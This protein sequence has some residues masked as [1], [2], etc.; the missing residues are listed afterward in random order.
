MATSIRP[1]ILIFASIST[2]ARAGEPLDY[3]HDVA[4]VMSRFG[5]NASSCHGKAEG[6]NGFKLS[7]FGNDPQ[8]DY[9][10]LVHQ[11]RGRRVFTAAPEQSLLLLKSSGEMPHEGGVQLEIG[12][13]E[14][15]QLLRWIEAGAP[16]SA[17][18]ERDIV[19]L[20]LEPARRVMKFGE[21][22]ELRAIA[23]FAGGREEDVS[24]LAEF[25]S[26]DVSMAEVDER[27]LVKIGQKVGQTAV[28]ARFS[29]KVAVFQA[30][31]PQPGDFGEFPQRP[32]HN[33]IDE[34]VDAN[35]QRLNLHPSE[36][37]D[38]ATFLRRVSLDLI[39]RLPA[40]AEVR[41]FLAKP[42]RGRLVNDLLE[43]TEFADFAALRWADLLRVDREA[44]G[45]RDAFAYYAW[46]RQALAENLPLDEF[47]RTVLTASGPLA[48]QPAGHFFRIT[49]KPGE[50]A[51][52]A[53]QVF[54]G[55]RITCAECHQHPFDRWTQQDYH[56][57][58]A[59]FQPVKAKS[60]GAT[61]FAVLTN[62]KPSVKHPRT[63]ELVVAHPLAEPMPETEPE[64]DP[65]RELADWMIDPENRW[66]ARNLA[67]RIWAHLLGRGLIEPV[68][69]LRDT[70]P[71]SN[72]ELLDALAAYLVERDFDA[73]ALIRLI[74]ASRTYQLSSTPN[75]AN[76]VDERNFSRSL[77]RRLPA[78]VL[79]DA[80]CDVTG[81]PEK[82][83]GV[84]AGYR[85]V[86]LWDSQ[87]QHY[88]LKLFGRPSRVT[89]CECERISGATMSQALHLMN[90]PQLQ[91]KLSHE[92]GRMAA[93][94][95]RFPENGPLVEELYLS[96]FSRYPTE[97]EKA[98]AVSY[99]DERSQIR[100]KA[101][102][103]LTWSLLNSVEFVFNH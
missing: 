57:L 47:A 12:S 73:K 49:K 68:D 93:L 13:R 54:L 99:L 65:R 48:E 78:E 75:D 18:E 1:F 98:N 42:D 76:A 101:V 38:D 70:N 2:L 51:A 62:G 86:Q 29:G 17:G 40:P 72:P 96:C 35:L 30:M 97:S 36:L 66:F 82:F 43:R 33:F 41:D 71:P 22:V 9:A 28:M 39:G 37:A 58:R 85:A 14:Y 95:G 34:L 25:L 11:A 24:W 6:Q 31:A 20:R 87:A 15:L 74:T 44:L 19:D 79:L 90:S 10:A 92:G 67:N 16:F 32:V 50:T 60:I 103:D 53:A 64:G 77:F 61:Q 3:V 21:E 89:A 63:G 69:D 26:N 4:P 59:F 52:M 88:F 94:T 8:G 56:G 100:R 45:H 91:A 80:V 7:V 23:K 81:V 27:G 55:V 5:C 46:I 83:T 102:E 84:P